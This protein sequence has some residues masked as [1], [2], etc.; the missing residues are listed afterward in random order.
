[1]GRKNFGI[2]ALFGVFLVIVIITS[3]CIGG[4]DEKQQTGG[5]QPSGTEKT[6]N[7]VP[8]SRSS[9]DIVNHGD[10][11]G[12]TIS[13]AI[14]GTTVYSVKTTTAYLAGNKMRT[15]S[16]T[17]NYG[18]DG[19]LELLT[20]DS[21]FMIEN[22]IYD[23]DRNPDG[24]W[25]CVNLTPDIT[26]KEKER[27]NSMFTFFETDPEK[28]PGPPGAWASNGTQNISGIIAEC[29]K[30]EHKIG[31]RRFCVHPQNNLML[32]N[33]VVDAGDVLTYRMIATK[34]DLS[35][36]PDSVFE[37]PAEATPPNT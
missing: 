13:Y 15:D 31:Y 26:D 24:E 32:L 11:K 29:Y 21:T 17:Y 18:W 27:W 33:E 25:G 6:E 5:K 20:V 30:H 1:M 14:M 7:E 3:G 34:V 10:L 28:A 37:L 19:K 9:A 23:C 2:V 16:R 36:P 4:E 12:Y 8:S 35:M 22:D